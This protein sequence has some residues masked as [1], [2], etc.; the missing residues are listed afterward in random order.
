MRYSMFLDDERMPPSTAAP[1]GHWIVVR[2]MSDALKTIEARGWPSFISFDHDL[3]ENEPTGHDFAKWIVSGDI[4]MKQIPP[5][6]N[7]YVH[8]QNPVGAQNITS[9]LKNYLVYRQ[10]T[11]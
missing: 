6:F 2:S 9:L 5:E 8:S 1:F 11:D 10:T 3:G 4:D 7:F